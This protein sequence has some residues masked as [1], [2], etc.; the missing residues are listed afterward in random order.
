MANTCGYKVIV[1][2]KKNA[3]YAFFGS[4][5]YFDEKIINSESGTEEEYTLKF[6]GYCDWDVDSNCGPWNGGFPVILPENYLEAEQEAENKYEDIIVQERSKMFEVEVWCNSMDLDD[7]EFYTYE[8]YISGKP[9]LDLC[10]DELEFEGQEEMENDFDPEIEMVL[11][12]IDSMSPEEIIE[13]YGVDPEKVKEILE[14]AGIN[15][16]DE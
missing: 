14:T 1:K 13:E 6:Q 12:M 11:E 7:P 10:P 8:H 3:C 9:I 5:P 2:G 4:M 15:Y 16:E